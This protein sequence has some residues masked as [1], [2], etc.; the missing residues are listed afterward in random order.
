MPQ[1]E[2]AK[3][4]REL[5]EKLVSPRGHD[6][7]GIWRFPNAQ[8]LD[9]PHVILSLLFHLSE[10]PTQCLH[11]PLGLKQLR[12]HRTVDRSDLLQDSGSSSDDPSSDSDVHLYSS[13]ESLSDW[14]DDNQDSDSGAVAHPAQSANVHSDY[15]RSDIAKAWS[16]RL[17]NQCTTA[18]KSTSTRTREYVILS[19]SYASRPSSG[20]L[21]LSACDLAAAVERNHAN[22]QAY[23]SPWP[24][25]TTTELVLVREVCVMLLGGTG[26]IFHRASCQDSGAETFQMLPV[27]VVHLSPDALQ[28]LVAPLI[29]I[30]NGLLRIRYFCAQQL[31]AGVQH[32]NA[33]CTTCATA[34]A[35]ASA[36][37]EILVR[38]TVALASVPQ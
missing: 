4:L 14:S 23:D 24:Y 22:N 35:F 10:S 21:A 2:S 29:G 1:L 5:V 6:G 7:G 34:Q 32:A 17:K 28:T 12:Q 18:R 19:A 33:T 8:V 26:D 27:Q 25:I 37:S 38:H 3:V 9:L 20:G 16:D 11:R 31:S 30:A 13:S 36:V 15:Q